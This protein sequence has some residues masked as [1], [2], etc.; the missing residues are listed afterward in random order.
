MMNNAERVN[1]GKDEEFLLDG[2]AKIH[3]TCG[4]ELCIGAPAPSGLVRSGSMAGAKLRPINPGRRQAGQRQRALGP[5]T[6]ASWADAGP[7]QIFV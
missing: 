3:Q 4:Q 1:Y 2:D 5:A 7:Q 6:S